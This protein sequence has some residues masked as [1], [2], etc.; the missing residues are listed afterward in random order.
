M[1]VAIALKMGA[2]RGA[3]IDRHQDPAHQLN[4]PAN[5]DEN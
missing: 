1:S 3:A 4:L 2:N 5:E